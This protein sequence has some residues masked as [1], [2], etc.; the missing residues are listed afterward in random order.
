MSTAVGQLQLPDPTS[1]W[2]L[3]VEEGRKAG[4]TFSQPDLIIGATAHHHGLT[5]VSRDTGEYV[6]ARVVVFNPWVDP[7][8]LALASPMRYR[9]L[10]RRSSRMRQN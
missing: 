3:P 4:H 1:G 9:R 8:S 10:A 7:W 6:K 5:I 2:R